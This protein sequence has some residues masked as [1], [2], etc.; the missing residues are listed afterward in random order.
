MK[1]CWAE[2]LGNCKGKI[3]KEH[4]ITKALS[5]E[6]FTISGLPWL[7]VEVKK[8]RLNDICC[9]ILCNKHNSNLS[10]FDNEIVNFK[11]IL[12]EASLHE[13]RLTQ[14][15]YGFRKNKIP[16]KYLINGCFLEKWF[17]KTLINTIACDS[18]YENVQ[19]DKILSYIYG[20]EKFKEPYG[21]YI[22]ASIGLK[23]EEDQFFS[24]IPIFNAVNELSGANFIFKGINFRLQIPT[25]NFPIKKLGAN[26]LVDDFDINGSIIKR[27]LNYHNKAIRYEHNGTVTQEINF[28]WN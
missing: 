17:C 27:Q 7:G 3:T 22:D 5:E 16:I 20:D 9:H 28:K 15:G 10:N 18:E 14:P 23:V 2:E 25:I 1:K 6:E 12:N 4:I 13:K 8:M 26:R 21:L 11:K 19:Y 24:I